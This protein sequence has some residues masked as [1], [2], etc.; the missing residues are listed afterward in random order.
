MLIKYIY[1][2]L[3]PTCFGVCYTIFRENIA[4]R[5]Q[6]LYAFRNVALKCKIRV[7]PFLIYNDVTMFKAK[8]AQCRKLQN[9]RCSTSKFN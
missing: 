7:Y 2:Q 1:H 8:N 4:L 3:P 5:A 6:R 9:N